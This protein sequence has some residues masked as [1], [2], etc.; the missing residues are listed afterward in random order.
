MT[1]KNQN[2]INEMCLSSSKK[3]D[4]ALLNYNPSD[5]HMTHTTTGFKRLASRIEE[6]SPSRCDCM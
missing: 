3:S 5:K 6:T 2:A 4:P 1:I